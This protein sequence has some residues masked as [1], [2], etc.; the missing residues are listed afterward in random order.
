MLIKLE[1]DYHSNKNI[2]K[3][4]KDRISEMVSWEE[5]EKR[6]NDVHPNFIKK[7]DI[8][9]SSLTPTEIRVATLIKMGCDTQEIAHF[10]WVS[11]RGIEQHRYRI[12]KKLKIKQNLTT[13]L[14]ST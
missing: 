4:F 12:K 14:I 6:F 13:F 2:I 11:R 9:N 5:F 10:L 1:K 8:D 7:L 3:L